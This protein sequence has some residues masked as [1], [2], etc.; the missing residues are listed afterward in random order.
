MNAIEDALHGNTYW[1]AI[2]IMDSCFMIRR[3][4]DIDSLLNNISDEE[5]GKDEQLPYWAEIWPSA[6]ALSEFVVEHKSDFKNRKIIELGCGLG[7]VG[8]SATAGGGE[9]LFTDNDPRALHF[10]QINFKRNFNR[11]ASVQLLDWRHPGKS[12]LFDAIIAADILYEKRWL[13]P[14]L[15]VIEKYLAPGGAA[16]IAGPD[17]TVSREIYEMIDAK[18]WKRQSVLKRTMVYDKLHKIIINKITKC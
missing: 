3:I 5:F 11:P 16:Y 2:N 8:I 10:T 17:R 9:V 12:E 7:L 14:V 1:E 18:K 4:K 15:D 13:E 6:V